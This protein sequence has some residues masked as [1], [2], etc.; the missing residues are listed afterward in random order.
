MAKQAPPVP[1]TPED[2]H[3]AALVVP[4]F[5]CFETGLDWWRD[6]PEPK[7]QW[8]ADEI[9]A[10]IVQLYQVILASS[11][12]RDPIEDAQCMTSVLGL[13]MTHC[14]E[15]WPTVARLL[16]SQQLPRWRHAIETYIRRWGAEAPS[17]IVDVLTYQ[18][19]AYADYLRTDHWK[20]LRLRKLRSTDYRCQA[21]N[22]AGTM[23]VHH[24]TY[25]R[26]GHERLE[27]LTVLCSACHQLFHEHEKLVPPPEDLL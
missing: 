16:T 20:A 15:L 3:F 2:E 1:L 26:R 4:Y 9:A 27:D 12:L 8:L 21:C 18:R 25:K 7:P 14:P 13:A 22:V 17:A 11:S 19:M 10:S 6:H 5:R 23:H 24:R